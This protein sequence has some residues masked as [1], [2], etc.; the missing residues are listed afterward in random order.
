[1]RNDFRSSAETLAGVQRSLV[2]SLIFLLSASGIGCNIGQKTTVLAL[3]PVPSSIPAGTQVVFTAYI[4]HKN[5]NFAGANWTL[6][7]SG[8]ACSPGCGTLSNPTNSGSAG[9]G[10]TAT[11]TYTAPNTAPNPN[12]ITITATSVEDPNSTGAATFTID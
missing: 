7:S 1:M 10:D 4:S 11:I 9:N 3:Q 8:T 6:T 12:S 2:C 5:D